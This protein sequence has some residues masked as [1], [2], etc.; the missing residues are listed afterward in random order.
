MQ[1]LIVGVGALAAPLQRVPSVQDCPSGLQLATRI[2]RLR[3]EDRV[4]E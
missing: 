4:C 2:P 3:Y 1:M